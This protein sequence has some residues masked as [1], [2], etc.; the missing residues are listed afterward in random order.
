M[1]WQTKSDAD[2]ECGDDANNLREAVSGMITLDGTQLTARK[3]KKVKV[4]AWFMGVAI[5][6]LLFYTT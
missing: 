2:K 6:A 4:N 3:L 5:G 1:A